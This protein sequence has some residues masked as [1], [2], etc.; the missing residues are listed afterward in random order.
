MRKGIIINVEEIQDIP[1]YHTKEGVEATIYDKNGKAIA[2][3]LLRTL[4]DLANLITLLGM[5]DYQY[6]YIED[7]FVKK[8]SGS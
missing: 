1:Y 3:I 5:P 8:W 2:V 7:G 6:I 4:Q